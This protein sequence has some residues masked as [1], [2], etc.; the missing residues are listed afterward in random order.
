[1]FYDYGYLPSGGIMA[2]ILQDKYVFYHIGRTGGT[3][4]FNLMKKMGKTQ[5]IG[6]HY[7]IGVDHCCPL[8]IPSHDY[9]YSFCVVRHPLAWM[10]SHYRY[11]C[12]RSCRGVKHW[13]NGNKKNKNFEE[14]I[15]QIIELRPRGYV[16]E[17]YSLFI[18]HCKYVLK[19]EN[20]NKEVNDLFLKWGFN[21]VLKYPL[22]KLNRSKENIV[23]ELSEETRKLFLRIENGMMRYLGYV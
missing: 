9:N 20:L 14:F 19:F 8:D 13:I 3:S 6:T 12:N 5:K 2:Y 17:C 1:L 21:N 18:P 4:I 15:K 11:L 22:S 7:G 10:E 23:T 16:T